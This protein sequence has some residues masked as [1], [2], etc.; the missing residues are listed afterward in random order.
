ME[1][2]MPRHSLACIL[3]PDLL[4]RIARE[5]D[6]AQR[7]AILDTLQI[8]HT[9]R[10]ARAETAARQGIRPSNSAA[11]H[12]GGGTPKRSIYDQGHSENYTHRARWCG[13]KAR[14]P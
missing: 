2:T 11:P 5:A 9:F 3:P 7:A 12:V 4:A 13:P 1:L 14:P 8:D 10:L 6:A